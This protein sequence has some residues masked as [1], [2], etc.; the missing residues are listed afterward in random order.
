MTPLTHA[1]NVALVQFIWWAETDGQ[2]KA[3]ELGYAPLPKE[4]RPWIQA[5]LKSVMAGGKA[6]FKAE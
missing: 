2:A 4:L 5:R 6:V 1:L 3:T